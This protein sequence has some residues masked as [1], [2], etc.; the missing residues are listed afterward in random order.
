MGVVVVNEGRTTGGRDRQTETDS[1]IDK[2]TGTDRQKYRDTELVC[3]S[4]V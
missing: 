1:L 4:V 2:Q 3:W